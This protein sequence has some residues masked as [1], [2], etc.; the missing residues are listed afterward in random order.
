[1]YQFYL[2]IQR[3]VVALI[4]VFLFSYL[5]YKILEFLFGFKEFFYR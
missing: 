2:Q 5:Q 1:M 3:V 4:M